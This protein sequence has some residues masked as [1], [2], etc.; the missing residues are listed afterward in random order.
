MHETTL[1]GLQVHFRSDEGQVTTMLPE[2]F[3][4][5]CVESPDDV[6]TS[7]RKE[8]WAEKVLQEDFG[9]LKEDVADAIRSGDEQRA[10]QRIQSYRQ[11]KAAVNQVLASPRV[12][13][14][15]EEDVDA[16]GAYVKETFAGKPE[17]V[18]LKQ[19]KNA[20]KLQYEA[21]QKRRDKK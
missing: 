13:E 10:M 5:A 12:T 7:I 6:M 21:Y 19:K 9:R 1:K 16:L 11:E 3:T 20:K 14:N 2:T 18:V 15:L 4:V 8:A 17:T